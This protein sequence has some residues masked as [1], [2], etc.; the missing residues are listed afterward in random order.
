MMKKS[1][2]EVSNRADGPRSTISTRGGDARG[3]GT[4]P[5]RVLG[6]AHPTAEGIE[7][8]PPAEAVTVVRAREASRGWQEPKIQQG[9]VGGR[10]SRAASVARWVHRDQAHAERTDAAA[11][12]TPSAQSAP[13]MPTWPRTNSSRCRGGTTGARRPPQQQAHV[14]S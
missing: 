2:G 8:A 7:E 13:S 11:S 10:H 1:Y 14:A 12:G 3:H 4:N 6:G 5:R 9:I